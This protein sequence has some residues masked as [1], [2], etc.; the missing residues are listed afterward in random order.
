MTTA[1]LLSPTSRLVALV[2]EQRRQ[3][4]DEGNS[5]NLRNCGITETLPQEVLEMIKDEVLRYYNL[6]HSKLTK[7][8]SRAE[9]IISF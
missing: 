9:S 7:T 5:L 3:S 6:E 2:S 4:K 1:P 8:G